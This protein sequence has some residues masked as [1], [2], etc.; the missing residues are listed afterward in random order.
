MPTDCGTPDNSSPSNNSSKYYY[1]EQQSLD[2][3]LKDDFM[4]LVSY[5]KNNNFDRIACYKPP[6]STQPLNLP[7]Q[8][9]ITPKSSASSAS[10]MSSTDLLF[11]NLLKSPKPSTYDHLPKSSHK[12]SYSDSSDTKSTNSSNTTV[13]K[14]RPQNILTIS[15][16]HGS[17]ID[18][19]SAKYALSTASSSSE[20]SLNNFKYA[21]DNDSEEKIIGMSGNKLKKIRSQHNPSNG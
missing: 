19:S 10:S 17:S 7:N 18:S 21:W 15:S 9:P 6:S 12:L 16:R 8:V 2:I 1:P 4:Q 20:L 11:T 13:P 14:K 3:L 5:G